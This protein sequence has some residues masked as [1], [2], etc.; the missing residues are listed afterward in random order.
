MPIRFRCAYCNQLMAISRRK[1]GNV[2]SCP[3]CAGDIIV[4]SPDGTAPNNQ[5]TDRPP[6]L[7]FEDPDFDADLDHPPNL[8]PTVRAPLDAAPVSVKDP[9]GQSTPSVPSIQRRGVFITLRWLLIGISVEMLLLL[10]VF[11]IGLIVGW[12]APPPPP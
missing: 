11:V 12:H 9:L 2:V 4:P 6:N 7:A 8:V 10:L 3:K 1:A 5:H